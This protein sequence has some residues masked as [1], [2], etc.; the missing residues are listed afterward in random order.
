[1]KR[2]FKLYAMISVPM[3]VEVEAEVEDGSP[4]DTL[5]LAAAENIVRG[6]AQ[7]GWKPSGHGDPE[8][9]ED[10]RVYEI[11]DAS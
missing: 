6:D 1:M 2:R 3:V 4:G 11:E 7:A 10:D 8:F 5:S 9:G